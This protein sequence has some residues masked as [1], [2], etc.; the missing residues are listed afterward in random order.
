[1]TD[2][3]PAR[4]VG[5]E[6]GAPREPGGGGKAEALRRLPVDLEELVWAM[7][8]AWRTE[9]YLD[10]ETGDV[11]SFGSEGRA[12]FLRWAREVDDPASASDVRV[13]QALAMEEEPER[14]V[15]VP[16]LESREIY[17]QMETFARSLDDDGLRE[18][19]LRA[20][21]GNGA[22]SRFRRE[23]DRDPDVRDAW[24]AHKDAWL[25]EEARWWLEGL[26]IE[27]VTEEVADGA[28]G[29]GT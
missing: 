9:H 17:E 18:N 1:M 27:T 13:A 21:A 2:P 19:L 16:P 8:G 7:E 11:V 26:G 12:V 5:P 20:L 15:W 3:S 28:R 25:K 10:V 14:F 24:F 29:D 6:T 22:F 4:D 23:L